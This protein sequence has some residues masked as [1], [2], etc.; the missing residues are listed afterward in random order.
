MGMSAGL[1]ACIRS[2]KTWIALGIVA[3]LGMVAISATMLLE[4][5]R[6]AWDKAAQTSKNLLQVIE[7]DIA[8]N[9]EIIDLTLQG[10]AE[11]LRMPGLAEVSPEFRQLALFDR[12][13]NA[14]DLGVMLVLDE[15]GDTVFDLAGWPPRRINSAERSYFQLHKADPRL[16][17]AIS[18]PLTSRLTGARVLVLSRRIDKPDGSFGGVVLG[19]LSLSYFRRLFDQIELGHAGTINLFHHDGTRIVRYP[20]PDP[21]PAPNFAKAPNFLRFMREGQGGFVAPTSSDRIERLYTFTQV[22]GLPLVLNVALSTA[23]IESEWRAKA[24]VIGGIVLTL[25]SLTIGLSLLCGWE[26]ERRAAAEKELARLSRT[27]VLTGLPNRRCFEE[28]FERYWA[29]GRRSGGPLCLLIADADHFKGYN[30]RHGHAVGDAVLKGLAEALSSSV[31]RPV[32]LVARIGGEEFAI[33]LPD[34]DIDGGAR[35]AETVHAAVARLAVAGEGADVGAV[36]VSIGLAG[37]LPSEGGTLVDLYRRADAA[38]YQAKSD[39]RDRTC[40]AP[41]PSERSRISKPG[42]RPLRVVNGAR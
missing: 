41:F 39:G 20:V 28:T 31:R 30:D 40:Q 2:T 33:L 32:D 35:V 16:G 4:L 42:A 36:T 27:D 9:V 18:Q 37:A 14:K 17:L 7:R 29:Q 34:T 12:A 13:V 19:S 26:L 10:I 21:E 22:G 1:A 11:T 3:T 5:R 6:D 25:C 38:L 24:L 23:E 8:R 15:N